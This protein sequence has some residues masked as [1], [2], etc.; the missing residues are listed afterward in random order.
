MHNYY[1]ERSLPSNSMNEQL[2]INGRG[3]GNISQLQG[4]LHLFLIFQV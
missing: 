2:F 3:W 1:Y 4:Q